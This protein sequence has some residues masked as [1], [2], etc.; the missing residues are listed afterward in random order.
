[1]DGAP[2][3]RLLNDNHLGTARFEQMPVR[4]SSTPSFP[5]IWR[6]GQIDRKLTFGRAARFPGL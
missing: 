6:M 4:A 1:M 3:D 5:R 2:E